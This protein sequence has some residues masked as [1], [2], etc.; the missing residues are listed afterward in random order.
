MNQNLRKEG[1]EQLLGKVRRLLEGMEKNPTMPVFLVADLVY[2]VLRAANV[3]CP[4]ELASKAAAENH[5]LSCYTTGVCTE[6]GGRFI[7]DQ[8]FYFPGVGSFCSVCHLK[9]NSDISGISGE[10][11]QN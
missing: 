5:A 10:S 11:E 6:C 8:L 9:S 1:R 4:D 3:Y 7:S 2:S